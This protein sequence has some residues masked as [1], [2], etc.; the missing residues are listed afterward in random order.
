MSRSYSEG[1]YAA[2]EHRGEALRGTLL[3][4]ELFR[5]IKHA[6]RALAL[7]IIFG[8]LGAVVMI[9]QMALLSRIVNQVFLAHQGL[10]Q[11]RFF[12][13]LLSGVIIVRAGLIWM[14]EVTA[15]QGAMRIKAEL[16][17]RL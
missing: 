10:T 5:Q 11:V 15:Q 1:K 8:A 3:N 4:R 9:V 12:L 7:T 2:S 6:R 13:L 14:R 16:R 17:E